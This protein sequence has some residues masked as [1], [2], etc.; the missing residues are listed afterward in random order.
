MCGRTGD[1]AKPWIDG[2][3]R[4][5]VKWVS[6][7]RAADTVGGP[8]PC[9]SSHGH[10]RPL[11]R[12]R[13]PMAHNARM[14]LDPLGGL[15]APLRLGGEFIG[16]ACH[17]PVGSRRSPRRRRRERRAGGRRSPTAI[18]SG[19]AL[20]LRSGLTGIARWGQPFRRERRSAPT[21]SRPISDSDAGSGIVWNTT[22]CPPPMLSVMLAG[23]WPAV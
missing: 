2:G 12:S 22:I 4:C 9:P 19:P 11:S 21:A 23:S 18:E 20:K 13:L 1:A 3:L 14:N 16:V 5:A 10:T 7:A 8:C 6:W 17:T 15:G